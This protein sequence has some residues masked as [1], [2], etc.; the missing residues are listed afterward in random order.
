METYYVCAE[1]PDI[2]SPNKRMACPVCAAEKRIRALE[3]ERDDLEG[4]A[5]D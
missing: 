4:S 1:H 2:T 3:A 5:D